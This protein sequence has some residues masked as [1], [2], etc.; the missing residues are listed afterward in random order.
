MDIDNSKKSNIKKFI[1]LGLLSLF[2]HLP[3]FSQNNQSNYHWNNNGNLIHL[4]LIPNQIINFADDSSVST[5]TKSLKPQRTRKLTGGGQLFE[6]SDGTYS[7]FLIQG[8]K[9]VKMGSPLFKEGG[10][11]KALPGGII[12]SFKEGI[13][14]SEIQSLCN[15]YDLK[16]KK[17]YSQEGEP[18]VWL[19]ETAPGLE[20]LRL[21]NLFI[22][23]HSNLVQKS[24]PNFWQPINTKELKLRD[25][26]IHEA[27]RSP[28]K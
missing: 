13:S 4:N 22:D 7:N 18:A 8:N 27:R 17:R 16:L 11:L 25:Y 6:L 10:M 24:K 5:V 28:K 3:G 12:V 1:L 2:L 9:L 21:A 19:I 26:Q 23:N 20:S 14:E 15:T